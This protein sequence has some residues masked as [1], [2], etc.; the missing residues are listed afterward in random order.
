MMNFHRSGKGAPGAVSARSF[1]YKLC[2]ASQPAIVQGSDGTFYVV[3]F[4]GF[5]G[6]HSLVSEVLGSELIMGLGLPSPGWVPIELS[7][8]FISENPG[9]WFKS[10]KAAIPPR[11]G[12]HFGSRLIEANDDSRTYQMIPHSWIDR[13]ENRA[14]FLGMLIVDL[15][16]NNC[17]RRQAVFLAGAEGKLS[18]SF[19]D[20]GLMFGG[21]FGNDTTCPRRA[22]VYDLDIYN[23]LWNDNNDLVVKE[24]LKRIDRIGGQAIRWILSSVPDSWVESEFD[25]HVI[26]QLEERRQR[27]PCLLNEAKETLNSTYPV[28]Y[29]KTRNAT[30][31]G[32]IFSSAVLQVF[33]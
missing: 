16:A 1:L 31:P 5:P 33:P 26:N 30:E 24:W 28:R 32:Q 2:G 19:I 20:N 10:G 13:I 6:T 27:L 7:S 15:W 4:D 11:P 3:K 22:M 9:L 12:L 14:D 8:R 17:D 25:R 21:R 23:G 18:A 29:H